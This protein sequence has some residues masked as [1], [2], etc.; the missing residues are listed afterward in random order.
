MSQLLYDR[1]GQERYT[2]HGQ[3]DSIAS[4]ENN[5][6]KSRKHSLA[7]PFLAAAIVAFGVVPQW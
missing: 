7:T 6:S 3:D 2:E 5:A 1:S 4:R